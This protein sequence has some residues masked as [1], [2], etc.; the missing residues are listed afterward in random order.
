MSLLETHEECYEESR[1]EN[2][3]E[4]LWL[5]QV[6]LEKFRYLNLL[7]ILA[8]VLACVFLLDPD[9]SLLENLHPQMVLVFLD[10]CAWV[11]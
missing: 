2:Q 5:G 9:L 8:L 11:C 7:D 6:H 3:V 10:F 1:V 4:N